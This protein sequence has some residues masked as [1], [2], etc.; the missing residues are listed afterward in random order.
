M[1]ANQPQSNKKAEHKQL[2]TVEVIEMFRSLNLPVTS[3]SQQ[4]GAKIQELRNFY[5]R[6]KGSLAV[7]LAGTPA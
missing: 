5:L 7:E 6:K 1:A 4:I 2:A 3:D